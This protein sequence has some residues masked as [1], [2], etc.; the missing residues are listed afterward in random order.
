MLSYILLLVELRLWM[1]DHLMIVSLFG[2]SFA[3]FIVFF[4]NVWRFPVLRT[5]W[6][7]V[8]MH[9]AG[10]CSLIL[11]ITSSKTQ[12]DNFSSIFGE[13]IPKFIFSWFRINPICILIKYKTKCI[14]CLITFC[15]IHVLYM[16]KYDLYDDICNSWF[17]FP[18]W[19]FLHVF[20][21]YC[22]LK[23]KTILMCFIYFFK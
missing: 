2:L 10:S 11:Q 3:K 23:V 8:L 5:G 4:H 19:C 6:H 14:V 22:I 15:L 21:L 12:A 18:F 20:H 1:E 16:S 13:K 17:I 9:T 7:S